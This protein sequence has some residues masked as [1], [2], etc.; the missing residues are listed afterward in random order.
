MCTTCISIHDKWIRRWN[1]LV[2]LLKSQLS[3]FSRSCL[4]TCTWIWK[5]IHVSGDTNI[6]CMYSICKCMDDIILIHVCTL[7]TFPFYC[8][9]KSKG[10]CYGRETKCPLQNISKMYPGVASRSSIQWKPTSCSKHWIALA[11]TWQCKN[12]QAPYHASFKVLN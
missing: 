10:Q 1:R 9:Q 2:P 8:I 6:T 4:N 11:K 7:V 12:Q 3:S 5:G